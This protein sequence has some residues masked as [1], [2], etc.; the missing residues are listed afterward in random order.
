MHNTIQKAGK[1]LHLFSLNRLGLELSAAEMAR[2]LGEPTSTMHDL[3][4]SMVAIGLLEVTRKNRYR[5]G[6]ELVRLSHLRYFYTQCNT[7]VHACLHQLSKETSLS[8]HYSLLENDTWIVLEFVVGS[9]MVVSATNSFPIDAPMFWTVGGQVLWAHQPWEH[10]EQVIAKHGFGSNLPNSVSLSQSYRQELERVRQ[11]GFAERIDGEERSI[12]A[13]VFHYPQHTQ[14][15][16]S[17]QAVIGAIT[18]FGPTP[19]FGIE[20]LQ[21]RDRLIQASQQ[22]SD[23]LR[24]MDDPYATLYPTK[25]T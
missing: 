17:Q 11:E 24:K 19:V 9:Q 14:N 1:V 6:W 10:V 22:L 21:L 25:P 4:H 8:A 13:P 18:L 2:Q 20:P 7:E 15:T 12:A 23:Q 16:Q 5:L 3:L